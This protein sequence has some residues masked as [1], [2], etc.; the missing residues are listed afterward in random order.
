MNVGPALYVEKR[1][2]AKH[3]MA[4]SNI[5][6]SIELQSHR[7]DVCVYLQEYF[8]PFFDTMEDW[9]NKYKI[10]LFILDCVRRYLGRDHPDSL[11]PMLSIV[12]TLG[13]QAE[14]QEAVTMQEEL[15]E[16]H[17][18][19]FPSHSCEH[20]KMMKLLHILLQ[21]SG[22]FEDA[23][24]TWKTILEEKDRLHIGDRLT[25]TSSDKALDSKLWNPMVKILHDKVERILNLIDSREQD[26]GA[27]HPDTLMAGSSLACLLK[28]QG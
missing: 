5:I 2:V 4:T 22:R 17:R 6:P 7:N 18:I 10:Q 1:R 21:K 13:Q 20:L 3:A 27:E 15:M 9:S 28:D 24:R 23:E 26:L 12:I 14:Y 8:V 25:R 19:V 11:I 16:A